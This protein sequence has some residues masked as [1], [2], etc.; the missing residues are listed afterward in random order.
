MPRCVVLGMS[1]TPI[2]ETPAIVEDPDQVI[3]SRVLAGDTEAY[4]ELVER[5][6]A[7]IFSRVHQIIGNTEDAEE[8]TQ[9]AFTRAMRSLPRFRWEASFS[10]W[11]FQIASNL[12]RNR[13][14]YWKRRRRERSLSFEAPLSEDGLALS[15]TLAAEAR[16]PSQEA[17]WTE[18]CSLI[19]THL[20]TLPETHR[21]VMEMRLF[22]HRSYE[23]ISQDL[24][25]PVGTV[26]SRIAR[27]REALGKAMGLESRSQIRQYISGTTVSG[28]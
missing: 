28:L 12:A 2:A 17:R 14:W 7:R 18:F 22:D 20:E 1:A 13:Y 16:D 24:Q 9:D 19:R 3:V 4:A 6:W 26:K 15:D 10:T 21:E 8:V 25:I 27:A 23:Q 11:L 5:Y